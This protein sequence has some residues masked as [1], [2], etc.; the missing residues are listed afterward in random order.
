MPLLD[1]QCGEGHCASKALSLGSG[2]ASEL[3]SLSVSP[4]QWSV[5][6]SFYTRGFN[7][8]PLPQTL[9]LSMEGRGCA[10]IFPMGKEGR[11]SGQSSVQ[12]QPCLE[13]GSQAGWEEAVSASSP[14]VSQSLSLL[15]PDSPPLCPSNTSEGPRCGAPS[16]AH[17]S[18]WDPPGAFQGLGWKSQAPS[19]PGGPGTWRSD[20]QVAREDCTN[21]MPL[22]C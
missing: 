3:P 10:G 15:F 13:E 4:Q 16:K 19:D 6:Y 8:R 21:G 12:A 11:K 20:Y 1:P 7:P 22:A 5:M 2:Q 17:Y 18:G 9:C 14:E